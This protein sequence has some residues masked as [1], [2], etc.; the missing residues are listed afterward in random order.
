MPN[1]IIL[2]SQTMQHLAQGEQAI[3]GFDSPDADA[4]LFFDVT[5]PLAPGNDDDDN[6]L[7]GDH[8]VC[9]IFAADGTQTLGEVTNEDTTFTVPRGGRIEFRAFHYRKSDQ[10]TMSC[11]HVVIETDS[12]AAATTS[13]RILFNSDDRP[14]PRIEVFL[15]F[16][17]FALEPPQNGSIGV[18]SMFGADVIT[19]VLGS[20]NMPAGVTAAPQFSG[21]GV[22]FSEDQ[23]PSRQMR[24]YVRGKLTDAAATTSNAVSVVSS[25][26]T[27]VALRFVFAAAGQPPTDFDPTIT[28]EI[29]EK[30]FGGGFGGITG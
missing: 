17:K 8:L 2:Y 26:T 12:G 21:D 13:A 7:D 24:M 23:W 4:V 19:S 28:V 25:E 18:T 14:E 6:P 15:S 27:Q 29:K 9:T 5:T 10:R 11:N 30:G 3:A 1:S 20:T 16:T 22:N